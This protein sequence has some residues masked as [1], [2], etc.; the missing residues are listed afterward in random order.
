MKTIVL[1]THQ[2]RLVA[3][4]CLVASLPADYAGGGASASF[5]DTEFREVQALYEAVR[6]DRLPGVDTNAVEIVLF[7]DEVDLLQ[8]I[9]WAVAQGSMTAGRA[10]ASEMNDA[11]R[12][13]AKA[14]AMALFEALTPGPRYIVADPETVAGSG[15]SHIFTE[16]DDDEEW[17]ERE[18]ICRFVFDTT[19]NKIVHM[20][21]Q[22]A[23]TFQP[24]TEIQISDVEDSLLTANV[25]AIAEPEQWGLVRSDE[26]PNFVAGT[27]LDMAGDMTP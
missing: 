6:D 23:G 22:Y 1:N 10:L 27:L 20:E 15:W 5:T 3:R 9:L 26:M 13:H 12:S 18:R 4:S 11:G 24:A 17:V 25:G 7:A 14:M 8:K 16:R 21:V 2:A 19:T